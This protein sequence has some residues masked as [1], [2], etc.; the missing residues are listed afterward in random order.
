MSNCADII[1]G[2]AVVQRNY[3]HVQ[4]QEITNTIL[5]TDYVVLNVCFFQRAFCMYEITYM[6]IN[7][8]RNHFPKQ[9]KLHSW[10]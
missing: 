8:Q 5:I 10:V 3:E 4:K 7:Q 2:Q 9:N 1:F 6:E